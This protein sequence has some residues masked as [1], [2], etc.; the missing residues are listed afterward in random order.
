[1][2]C[3]ATDSAHAPDNASGARPATGR[4]A[5]ALLLLL[6]GCDLP[7]GPE[8][9][10]SPA[11]RAAPPPELI[12]TERFRAALAGAPD[13]AA[14]LEADSETLAARAE[15]LRAR[16]AALDAPVLAPDER[17]RLEDARG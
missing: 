9:E 11:V 17:A 16:G 7:H 2:S 10:P 1:M 8:F 6:A 4:A 3:T 5:A 15:A 12:E 14:R 13:A